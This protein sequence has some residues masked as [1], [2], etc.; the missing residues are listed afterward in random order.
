MLEPSR[1]R[2][3]GAGRRANGTANGAAAWPTRSK[4]GFSRRKAE[5]GGGGGGPTSASGSGGRSARTHGAGPERLGGVHP[6]SGALARLPVG[7]GRPGRLLRRPAAAVPVAGAV[8][9]R[10]PDP[11]GAPVRPDQQPGQPRRGRQGVLLLPRRDA[12]VVLPEDA[13]Q[14]PAA[15][16]PLRATWSPTTARAARPTRSTSCSTPASSTTTA[17]STS[18]VE[19]AKASPEDLLMQ[20]TVHNRGP[21]EA[22]AARA[23]HA[24]VPAHLVLGRRR[25]AARRC[26]VDADAQGMSAVVARARATSGPLVLRRRAGAGAGDRERDQQR[27]GLRHRPTTTPVRQGRHRPGR[28]ARRDRTRSTRPASGPRRPSHHVADGAGRAAARRSGC[29]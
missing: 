5:F 12:D 11:E 3:S 23:A 27:A 26:D 19:Y 7:R 28:R 4:V 17:T 24:L 25:R 8:E 13:L 22:R 21:D 9:R 15:R 20:V 16:V 14:V 2:R 18:F 10:R 6:R 1:R 29:G